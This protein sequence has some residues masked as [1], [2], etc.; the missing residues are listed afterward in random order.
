MWR[1]PLGMAL[2]MAW[3]E[4]EG[5]YLNIDDIEAI[6]KADSNDEGFHTEI[7]LVSGMQLLRM[8]PAEAAKLIAAAK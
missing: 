7:V 5:N 2:L 8:M 6:R 1:W 3:V 4:L